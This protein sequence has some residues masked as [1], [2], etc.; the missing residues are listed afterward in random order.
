MRPLREFSSKE[1]ALFNQ[2]CGSEVPVT[3]EIQSTKENS[4]FCIN[5]LTEK[6]V[7]GL[8]EGFPSTVPTIFRT[9]DKLL[10]EPVD[11]GDKC[12]LCNGFIDTEPKICCTA[13][14]AGMC[15]TIY[16]LLSFS[17]KFNLFLQR[18]FQNW[19]QNKD[20]KVRILFC[21][22]QNYFLKI[23]IL[24]IKILCIGGN[25]LSLF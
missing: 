25:T 24:I 14:E 5:K 9:G 23:A 21:C 1:I 20:Q 8:Q 3:H 16:E 15:Y 2:H 13:L 18:N 17:L 19:F 6:F 7:T 10:M 11:D 4:D 12:V 22:L